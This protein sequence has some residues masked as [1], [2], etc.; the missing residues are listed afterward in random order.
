M[1]AESAVRHA[2][3][4]HFE[5]PVAFQADILLSGSVQR[6]E[7]GLTVIISASFPQNYLSFWPVCGT[8]I[9]Q[10]P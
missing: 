9:A 8:I 6:Q 1:A 3:V 10:G 7:H 4:A 5:N 2:L